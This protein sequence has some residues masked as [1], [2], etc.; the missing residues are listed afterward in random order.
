M[1]FQHAT[2]R[3]TDMRSVWIWHFFFLL[4]WK[5]TNNF[6]ITGL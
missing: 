3:R 5:V 2:F 4:A 6:N 1:K